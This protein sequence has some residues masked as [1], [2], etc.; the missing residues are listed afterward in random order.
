MHKKKR[1]KLVLNPFCF[2]CPMFYRFIGSHTGGLCFGTCSYYLFNVL[3]I[4]AKKVSKGQEPQTKNT[5][6]LVEI[7]LTLYYCIKSAVCWAAQVV[8]LIS[9][10]I[11]AS[12]GSHLVCVIPLKGLCM[13]ELLSNEVMCSVYKYIA[14]NFQMWSTLTDFNI[15][16]KSF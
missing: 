8:T 16:A 10:I 13:T 4:K 9:P 14:D 7:M 3:S 1:H 2:C 11:K 15:R 5:V 12:E 6:I